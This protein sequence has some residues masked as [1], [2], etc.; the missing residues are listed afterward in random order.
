MRSGIVTGLKSDKVA[1]YVFVLPFI[2]GFTAFILFPMLMSLVFSFTRY[3]ILTAPEFTGLDNYVKMFTD[4]PL[5]W[6]SFQVTM[7]YVVFSVPLRLLMA[8]LVALLLARPSRLSGFSLR[9]M[10]RM[11]SRVNG[12]M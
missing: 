7:Y 10:R 5:F 11:V 3:N 6:K 1:A 9:M 4:D 2:I 8:L 12:S